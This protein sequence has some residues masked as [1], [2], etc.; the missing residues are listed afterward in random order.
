MAI[1]DLGLV[2]ITAVNVAAVLAELDD[3]A[4]TS[5]ERIKNIDLFSFED[6]I[7][8]LCEVLPDRFRSD[9][10]PAFVI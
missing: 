3:V 6:L 8:L 9:R 7:T 1:L 4:A 10:V 5:C 2:N